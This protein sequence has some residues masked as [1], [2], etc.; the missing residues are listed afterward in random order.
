MLVANQVPGTVS[1]IDLENIQPIDEIKVGIIPHNIL[2]SSNGTKAYVTIQGEDKVVVL[3]VKDSFKKIAE[4]KDANGPH[5]LDITSDGNLLFVD[6]AASSD[7]AVVNTTTL[8]VIKNISVS[9]GHH[10]IDVSTDNKRAYASGIGDDKISVIDVGNLNLITQV[11]VGKGP[12]AYVQALMER[13]FML[14]QAL[15]MSLLCSILIHWRYRKKF[16]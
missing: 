6:N 3:D 11:S 12:M 13:I 14:L 4:I 5:D 7:V 2:F 10:G 16:L 8:E 1:V 15:P 9:L